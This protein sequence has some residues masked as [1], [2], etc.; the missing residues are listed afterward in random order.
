MQVA[1]CALA[2][3][4][5]VAVIVWMASNRRKK[6]DINQDEMIETFKEAFMDAMKKQQAEKEAKEES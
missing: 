4:A 6:P 5:M 2:I 3:L 1:I